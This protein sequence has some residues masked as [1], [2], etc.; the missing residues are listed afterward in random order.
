MWSRYSEFFHGSA[1]I[2][3]DREGWRESEGGKD[4]GSRIEGGRGRTVVP[5][6]SDRLPIVLASQEAS[7]AWVSRLRAHRDSTTTSTTGGILL[8]QRPVLVVPLIT[9]HPGHILVDFLQQ[10]LGPSPLSNTPL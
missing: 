6:T 1:S 10:V 5:A 7:E 2:S 3:S 9:I 4:G 8:V